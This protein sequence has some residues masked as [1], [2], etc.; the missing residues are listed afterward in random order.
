MTDNKIEDKWQK[1]WKDAK[2]FQSNPD[3][4]EKVFL[5][6]A[7]P[8]PSGAMHVG[9]G[10]TYTVPDVYARFKRM[11]GYNVL[12]P[13]GWHVT[14]APV[15]GIAKR[16]K[17][18]DPWTLDIYQNVHKVPLSELEKFTDPHYIVKY[19]SEEYRQ[20]MTHLGYSIDW[21]REFTTIDPTYQKFITWQFAK[22]NEKGLVRRGSHPVKYCP[23]DENPV[24]DHDLLEGEGVAINELTLIKFP[25]NGIYLVAATFRPETLFGAT[26]IW[27]NPD[28]EYVKVKMDDEEWIIS[29][30]AYENL[31]NQKNNLELVGDVDAPCLIGQYVENPVTGEKHIILPASFVDP[32]YATGVVYSVPA[33]APADYI[34]LQDLKNDTETLEEYGIQEEVEKIQPIGLIGLKGFGE[35]PAVEMIEQMG[36]KNQ[37]DPKLK[38]AT[39][40]MYK[41]EH[42]KGVIKEHVTDYAGFKVPQA[43]DAIKEHLLEVGKGD[44]MYEFAEK[45]VICR[46][47][48]KC[49]VKI[50]DNQ[51]FL[52]YSDEEWTQTTLNCLASMNTV[53]GEIR[54]NFEYYLNWLHD[55]ACARR[56]GLGTPLPWDPQWLIEPLSDST[57]YM[58]YYTIA[59][60]LKK[61][62]PEKMDEEFFDHVFLDKETDKNIPTAIKEE[63]NYW[64]PLDWRL[65]AKD[66]VGNHLSFHLFHHA[67]IFP[68]EKWPQ[69]V[70]VFG[71][72]LLEGNKMSSSKGNIILLE[73]AIK[74]HGADVVRLFLMSSA[75]P[76]QDFDWR[77]KEVIGTKKRLE[78]FI[79][80]AAMVDELHGSQIQLSDYIQ[81]PDADKSINAWMISQVNQRVR[82][83]TQAL[84]G[85]Q[86]RKALQ[87]ALF[88][89]KKD[90]DHYLHR[91]D[92]E[93]KEGDGQEE[94][95]QV[96]AYILGIWIRLMAPFTP[97]A[98]EEL[99]ERH[100]GQGFASQAPWPEVDESLIDEKVHK[101]EEII[102]G[103]VDDVREIKKITKTSPEKIHVYLAPDWKWKVFEIAHE[104]GKPD[105]G[106]I[107]G[108]SIKANIHDDK[109]ELA[110]FAQKIA[111]E[112]TRINYVGYVDEKHLLEEALDY[113]ARE[114]GAQVIIYQEPTYDPKNKA[115]NALPYK[116]ALY[117]E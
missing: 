84:E 20:V 72:G 39:N 48:T 31:L 110:G 85:F 7:Y 4:R 108:R 37:N 18:Q 71:M 105:I 63:F 65:S 36:V 95:I 13:M 98:C 103:L 17:R 90:I 1:K 16:I 75:E 26:N 115:K 88:L 83:A 11:Q 91:V 81:A 35:H 53:P 21:R 56:I 82:D 107:M 102:Q 61:M 9:H 96:L 34:A 42:A 30:K 97:H 5:T 76:W 116:P 77:E 10:R 67:A 100:G 99:W 112:M 40:E 8:Y 6:V 101:G 73:D 57:I 15:I 50:L 92:H 104:V 32:D 94:I 69:G 22:L 78:W 38:E 14:G 66:L 43:R 117:I 12:F 89:F 74:I 25:I 106:Q 19:F 44:I 80:F 55:W 86:T 87:E 60:H 29:Q 111:R 70:V 33:H 114:T 49:V 62:D 109:K 59:P 2:L 45:P 113:I 68:E 46:C 51:W 54:S 23:D 93:L 79:G 27:L 24:G 52:K 47:G 3:N 28:E 58:S 41:L 64:Y